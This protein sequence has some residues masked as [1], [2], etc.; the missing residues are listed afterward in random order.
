MKNQGRLLVIQ[1][2]W[3]QA[4]HLQV[5][6]GH[7][8]IQISPACAD[9]VFVLYN[10]AAIMTINWCKLSLWMLVQLKLVQPRC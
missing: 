3:E 10:I 8:L 5:V 9:E 7:E 4:H 6:V 1:M 2:A